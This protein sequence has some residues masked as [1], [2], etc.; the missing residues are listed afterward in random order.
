MPSFVCLEKILPKSM[1]FLDSLKKN[2]EHWAKEI[3]EDEK[4]LQ[5]V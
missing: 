3:E 5:K 1:V 4:T 2:K